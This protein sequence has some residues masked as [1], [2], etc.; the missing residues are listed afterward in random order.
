M[1]QKKQ[2]WLLTLLVSLISPAFG[3]SGHDHSHF[4][5]DAIHF[6]FYASMIAAALAIPAALI[7]KQR[8]SK[9]SNTR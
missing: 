5:S 1:I 6:V 3:H 4:L 7:I 2:F 9:D 8:R